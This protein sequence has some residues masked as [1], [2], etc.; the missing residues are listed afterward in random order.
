MVVD[1][2]LV[3]KTTGGCVFSRLDEIGVWCGCGLLLLRVFVAEPGGGVFG[4]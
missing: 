2:T 3:A 1:A 4:V